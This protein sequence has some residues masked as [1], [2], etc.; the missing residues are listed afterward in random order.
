MVK[1]NGKIVKPLTPDEKAVV[2]ERIFVEANTILAKQMFAHIP[3]VDGEKIRE[4]MKR[5]KELLDLY[6]G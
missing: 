6:L 3:Y 4:G 5:L 2:Y 1:K